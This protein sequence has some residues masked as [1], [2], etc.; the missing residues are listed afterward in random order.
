M[1]LVAENRWSK[2][3]VYDTNINW[4]ISL[5]ELLAI[6]DFDTS[7]MFKD[8]YMTDYYDCL[9]ISELI[10]KHLELNQIFEI[11]DGDKSLPYIWTDSH[12]KLPSHLR[13]LC[14]SKKIFL[15]AFSK[16][17]VDSEGFTAYDEEP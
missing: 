9:H 10:Q 1:F 13:T 6:G 15:L 8:D 17:C 11:R 3:E 16:F 12:N 2:I 5:I 14:W 7:T 4:L